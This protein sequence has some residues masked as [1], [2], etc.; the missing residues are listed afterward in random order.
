[1]LVRK[2]KPGDKVVWKKE[3][4]RIKR[5]PL[6][7]FIATYGL[8]PFRVDEIFRCAGGY[9]IITLT[10]KEDDFPLTEDGRTKTFH[11]SYF[12]LKKTEK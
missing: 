9:Q 8:G 1:M 5:S 12:M 10:V 3:D 4:P 7:C 11:S 6:T 2:F